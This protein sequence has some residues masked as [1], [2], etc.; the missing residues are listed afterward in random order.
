MG[1]HTGD[2]MAELAEGSRDEMEDCI[3]CGE[4]WYTIHHKDGVCYKCQRQGKA[5]RSVLIARQKLRTRIILFGIPI[6]GI[7]IAGILLF[8]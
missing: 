5:G 7:L 6:I 4:R 3:H 1:D 8:T 2:L